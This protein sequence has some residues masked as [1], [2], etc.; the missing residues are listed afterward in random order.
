MATG[1]EMLELARPHIGEEYENVLVP[2]NNANWRGPWDCAEFMSWLVF[3]TAGI[4]YGCVD[5]DA[6]PTLVEA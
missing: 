2:K 5:S 6:D 4:L 1:S 3:Q